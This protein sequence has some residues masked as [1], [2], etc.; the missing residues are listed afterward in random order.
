MMEAKDL[1][2]YLRV[3]Q[4]LGIVKREV[5]VTKRVSKRGGIY[6]IEDEYFRF[7]YRFVS[8]HYEDIEGLNPE[9]AIEDF[10]KNFNTYLGGTTFEKV[11]REFLIMLSAKG[12]HL[13]A[14]TTASAAGGTRARR[15]TSLPSTSV[16]RRRCS[17]RLSGRS[18]KRGK[19]GGF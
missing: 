3:L 19:R 8:P 13:P 10:R 15:L 7:Y 11:A 1:P 16:K 17:L 14:C 18:S 12:G 2:A 9:P 4:D 6:T 5:P